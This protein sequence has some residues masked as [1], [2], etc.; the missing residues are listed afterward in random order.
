[1]TYAF[2][3]RPA[4]AR[5]R[6]IPIIPESESLSLASWWSQLASRK[7]VGSDPFTEGSETA[8]LG[9]D[10]QERHTEAVRDELSEHIFTKFMTN[11]SRPVDAAGIKGRNALLPGEVSLPRV[12][13]EK[14]AEVVVVDSNEP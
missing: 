11:K 6:K 9:T 12:A 3:V 10:E 14:S 1:M 7:V 4:W 5:Y 2:C 8:N 13:K